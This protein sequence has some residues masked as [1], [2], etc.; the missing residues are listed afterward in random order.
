[1]TIAHR[2]PAGG[3]IGLVS[4]SHVADPVRYAPIIRAITGL[5]FRV[6]TG[7]NLY[8]S[9][10]GYSA[11][12]RERADD[13]NAMFADGEIDMV[14]LGGGE[15]A[16]ELLP[17]VDFA[18]IVA[19]PKIVMS[20]S[21]GTTLLNTIHAQTGLVTY[22]GQGPGTF[23][24]LRHYDYM[25]FAS[26]LVE[27]CAKRWVGN[28]PWQTV[29]PGR[30]E[31]MLI[32]GYVDNFAHL[33]GSRYFRYDSAQ[34]HLLF[35]E[36]HESFSNV[37][38][39]SAHLA[40]I[41]QSDFMSCVSGLLFGHYSN[42]TNLD[43]LGRLARFGEEY[44]IPVAYCDDFGHGVNHAILPIGMPASMDSGEKWLEFQG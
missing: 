30:C 20:Y 9:T 40:Y 12:E 37:N 16:V 36:D 38:A 21:D 2:L 7:E 17:Y 24:D 35:L 41:E 15:G 28:S 23:A 14:F 42:P 33:L 34:K 44:R 11:T 32:G 3:T 13:L 31:G 27:G 18:A 25:Q 26:H 6:K 5:G 29:C 19:H 8:K 4:P 39:L 1:M 10:Y 22:Y 43:L